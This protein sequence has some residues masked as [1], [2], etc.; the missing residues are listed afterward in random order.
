[1]RNI[2]KMEGRKNED[3]EKNIEGSDYEKGNRI[4]E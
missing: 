2:N 1:M 3:E 4:E